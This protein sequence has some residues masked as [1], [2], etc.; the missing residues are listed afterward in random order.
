[1]TI[2]DKKTLSTGN[3]KH[4]CNLKMQVKKTLLFP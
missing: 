2:I 1:M 3:L 4:Y